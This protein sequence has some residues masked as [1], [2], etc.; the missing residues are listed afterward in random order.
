MTKFLEVFTPIK[1]GDFGLT[2]EAIYKSIQYGGKFIPVYGGTEKHI[3]ERFVSKLGK[4]KYDKQITVFNGDGI[5]ISLD[6]SAGSM[7]W[8]SSHEFA[9]NHHAGFFTLLK[10][11]QQFIIPE[12]F[13]LFYEKEL[14]K[15]SISEGSK[16][17][18]KKTIDSID[19]SFPEIDIQKGIMKKIEPII[20]LQTKIKNI[21]VKTN[22]INTKELS[23]SYKH[24]QD[25]QIPL[26]KIIRHYSGNTNLTESEIYQKIFLKGERFEV[27][28]S[29]TLDETKLGI[30][31][32]CTLKGKPLKVYQNQE[33]IL[34]IRNGK[35]GTTFFLNKG[36]FT[37]TDHAYI[38]GI[39][40]NCKYKISL[41]WFMYQYRQEFYRYSS[42]SDNATWDMTGFFNNTYVDI[43]IYEE[44]IDIVEKMDYLE[45]LKLQ[46][47]ALQERI[48]QIFNRQ[49]VA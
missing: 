5:I 28:S 35:A 21:I 40:D 2:E 13:S 45:K 38:L 25:T 16:T 30:I 36:N 48:N 42:S 49:M 4:T 34:V 41:K 20:I 12:F 26:K 14:R 24:Y 3:P 18:T 19:F 46:I 11:Q 10:N 32:K 9:L 27:L 33:G 39:K 44:Q 23:I 6:G 8:V 1:K 43:P 29:S 17:L 22:S 31:P 15:A 7:T 47:E 37:I